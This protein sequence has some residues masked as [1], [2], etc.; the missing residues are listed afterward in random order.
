MHTADAQPATILVVDD[1]V[2]NLQLL[3]SLLGG[4][5]YDVRPVTNGRLAL[6]AVER[7]PPDLVLLDINMPAMD[8]YDVCARLKQTDAGRDVPVIFLT[9]MTDTA[10]KLKA[11]KAGGV[12][13]ITKPFQIDEVLARVATHIALRR[14]QRNLAE[15]HAR[16]LVV[17]DLREKLFHM[18]VHDMRSPLMVLAMNLEFLRQE[19]DGIASE[20]AKTDLRTSIRAAEGLGGMANEL[21]DISRLEEG[22]MPLKRA[23]VDLVGIA[24]DVVT[25]LGGLDRSVV[26]DIDATGEVMCECDADIVRR[27]IEN[28]L[29]NA[30]TH[31][32][33][34]GRV[35]VA[36]TETAQ[37]HRVAVHD[38]GPG[39][40]D[41]AK[42]RIFEKFGT[43]ESRQE[44]TRQSVGLG[45]AFCK[46]A[47][48]AHNGTIG[49]DAGTPRGSVFWF[50]LP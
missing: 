19:I 26:V 32:P 42:Q 29:S 39:V 36:L 33:T 22:Q 10:A 12:D 34:G 2:E 24:R 45:L 38:E 27:V 44:R 50:E 46:L 14:A 9:A 20:Q 47:V 5:G 4:Q 37:G 31:S 3:A 7:D 13:Y 18:V 48:Q 35:C 28:L 40:P 16:L 30:I 6:Q 25:R 23:R 43:A 17:E 49:V 8:G 11:F 21:L 41:E 1:T 15:E